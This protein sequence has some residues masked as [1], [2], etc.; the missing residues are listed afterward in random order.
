MPHPFS[1]RATAARAALLVS[2]LAACGG[3]DPTATTPIDG[4]LYALG[5]VVIQPDG[6]RTTYVQTLSSLDVTR[7]DNTRAVEIPGN[8]T[9][10]I[11]DGHA[12]VGLA[13][14]PTVVRYTPD[15]AGVLREDGRVNFLREG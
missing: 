2:V 15:A 9:L 7:V 1:R 10:L 13:E 5:S 14:E 3:D 11:H 4:P 6:R 12:F 8:G